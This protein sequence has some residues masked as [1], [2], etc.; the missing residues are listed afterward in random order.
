M[1]FCTRHNKNLDAAFASLSISQDTASSSDPT[2]NPPVNNKIVSQHRN[3]DS[4][5]KSLSA[6]KWASS[7]TS[8]SNTT[9]SETPSE[10]ELATILMG[11]RKL[12]EGLLATSSTAVSPVFS[13]RVHV[14]N[15][16]VAILALHPPSYHPSLAYIL[17]VLH[18]EDKPLP[19]PEL[20][21]M[22]TYMILDLALR[23][24]D[25]I[26]AYTLRCNSQKKFG[27]K[28]RFVDTILRSVVTDNWVSFWRVRRQVDGYVRALMHWHIEHIRKTTLK[29][30]G[31]AYMTVDL[32][33]LLM[34]TSSDEMSW[35]ELVA[36]EAVGWS[37]E[38]GKVIIR[39]PKRKP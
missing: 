29:A 22:T 23:Q 21:E 26:A 18:T 33:W 14:F 25:L 28:D 11:L 24:R 12:R 37:I 17:A 5:S 27:Y 36:K 10:M 38:E 19:D 4:T 32:K 6:S 15:I 20:R 1:Q 3:P 9:L 2:K 30:F 35:D 13:Q 16:R 7:S 8:A 31:R 39:K 34:S